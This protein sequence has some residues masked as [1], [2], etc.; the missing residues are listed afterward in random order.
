MTTPIVYKDLLYCCA[1][2]GKLSC[3]DAKT[4]SLVYQQKLQPPGSKMSSAF[5]A[6]PVAAADRIYFTG[7]KGNIYVVKAGP[8]FELLAVN[9]MDETCMAT[10]A[11][12]QGVLFFRTRSHLVAVGK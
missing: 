9:Q 5:S 6:S 2:N 3:F 10:P 8:Q 7:E 1:N 4:G 11:I 12:S